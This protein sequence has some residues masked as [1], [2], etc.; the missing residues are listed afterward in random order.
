MIQVTYGE[1][2]K[3]LK[4]FWHL[5]PIFACSDTCH[6][7]E[8]LSATYKVEVGV[9]FSVVVIFWHGYFTVDWLII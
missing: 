9:E 3:I 5:P 1:R 6:C 8:K 7:E 2:K 4:I